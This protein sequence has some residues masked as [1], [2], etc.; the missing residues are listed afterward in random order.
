MKDFDI[1]T[2]FV[3]AMESLGVWL[4]VAIGAAGLV[5]LVYGAA[6]SRGSRFGGMAKTVALLAGLLAALAAAALLPGFTDAAYGDLA[7]PFDLAALLIA[8]VG[9][10][11][12]VFLGLLPLLALIAGRR[13]AY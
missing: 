7:V 5:L 11:I 6:L 2:L 9:I 1:T 10:G 8:A 13:S 12:A 4:W 3:I